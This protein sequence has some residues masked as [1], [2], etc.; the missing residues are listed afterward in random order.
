MFRHLGTAARLALLGV[1][2]GAAPAPAGPDTGGGRVPTTE[3]AP[4]PQGRPAPRDVPPDED[5]PPAEEGNPAL[6]I[7]WIVLALGVILFF[8]WL[9][10]RVGDSDSA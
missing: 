8:V 4:P 9:A 2:L 1:V 6:G 5:A 10:T 7:L 3:R